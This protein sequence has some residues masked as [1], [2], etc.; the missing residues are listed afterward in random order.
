MTTTVTAEDITR[1]PAFHLYDIDL[2]QAQLQFLTVSPDTFRLSAFLDNRIAF[3]DSKVHSLGIDA[4][5]AACAE[6]PPRQTGTNF[7]FHSSFCCSSLLARSLQIDGLTLV[8]REPWI[9][10]RLA[11]IRRESI[12]TRQDWQTQSAA[13][14]DMA[15]T[16]LG[17]TWTE[18][19][20]VLIKPTNIANN[21]ATDMLAAR[22]DARGIVLYSDL[23]T[24]LISNLKKSEETRQK[25]PLLARLFDADTGF[26]SMFD[27]LS[28]DKLP[29]LQAAVAVWYAQMLA[30]RG[31]LTADTGKRLVSLD[32]AEL[33]A[34][35]EEVLYAAARHLKYPIGTQDIS[36]IVAGPTW[37]THAKDPF[38]GYDRKLRSE[39]N[40]QI[41]KLHAEDIREAL[42]WAESLERQRPVA[43]PLA[44]S[45]KA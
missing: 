1:N 27:G 8:L 43:L 17:K 18:S 37:H 25:M 5:I 36:S 31:L 20:S 34:R 11:D 24:F 7:I 21:L 4:V 26:A 22:A 45:L 10:R 40:L 3:T 16:L 12:P 9:L 33:L 32:S 13:L 30:F 15:L 42:R 44:G 29:P 35:P 6:L 41:S 19:Q 38:S 23:E 14:V 2:Q 39:E 28:L